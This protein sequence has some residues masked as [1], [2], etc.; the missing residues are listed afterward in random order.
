M[1]SSF[2]IFLTGALVFLL[3]VCSYPASIRMDY[4]LGF[5]GH[6]QTMKWTPITI[7][8]ENQGRSTEG[9]LEVI[10]TSGSEY[11][12]DVHPTTYSTEVE[13]PRHSKKLSSMTIL[14]ET[15][16]HEMKI[17]FRKGSRVMISRS[18]LLHP[19][20]TEK[21]MAVVADP[22]ITPEF[23]SVLP[24]ELY[25]VRVP[26][27][28]LP[29]QWYG[30]GGVG[31]LVV[32]SR[33]LENLRPRQ[34]RA[35]KEWAGQGGL[36]VLSSEINYGPLLEKRFQDLMP[37]KI[38][39]HR[40]V[41]RLTSLKDF[42]GQELS[43]RKPFFILKTDVPHPRI[44]TQE[45]DIPVI[46]RNRIGSGHIVFPAFD[47]RS[48]PFTQWEGREA[49][50]KKIYSLRTGPGD[51]GI[52]LSD[53]EIMHSLLPGAESFRPGFYS[54][55]LFTFF[56]LLC[57][58]GFY[59]RLGKR[60]GK[61]SRNFLFLLSAI[62]LF[63]L[64][65]YGFFFHPRAKQ[66]L[67]SNGLLSL[68][69]G[70][71]D[72][73]VAGRYLLGLF[74]TSGAGYAM[75]LDPAA[76]PVT[77]QFLESSSVPVLNVYTLVERDSGQVIHG[78]V[79]RWSHIYFSV[80]SGIHF[81]LGGEATWGEKEGLDLTIENGTP[82]E[83]VDCLLYFGK[84]FMDVDDI[85]PDNRL[86][87]HIPAQDIHKRY[88]FDKQRA[89]FTGTRGQENGSVDFMRR[90]RERLEEDILRSIDST[91][92]NDVKNLQL[93]GWIRSGIIR[94]EFQ[95]GSTKGNGLTFIH[96]NIPVRRIS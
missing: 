91:Y 7:V 63:S 83:I 62:T 58:G 51:H 32:N 15:I 26:A 49:F 85:G 29:E 22:E 67:I 48:A 25:P 73:T 64:A 52:G 13:L 33:I 20:Y 55:L 18:V 86:E 72:S 6:F 40:R 14:I 38:S 37:M 39:G 46:V 66:S 17:R 1:R 53:Q 65:G 79:K 69:G 45:G 76:Y 9:T 35:M 24:P 16:T 10:V 50:W 34:Y 27:R 3:P 44:L 81:S 12:G 78:Y 89:G 77:G 8:L 71:R 23:L 54:T 21:D 75:T 61:R 95:D 59:Y 41:H 68:H 47:T 19:F 2:L 4:T 70:G 5:D 28:Y 56:Y 42:D 30:Y 31:M 74:S 90:I 82:F 60:S 94:P 57:I 92:G 36:I 87:I 96:W 93:T 43:G 84:H 11:Q 88:V 80:R